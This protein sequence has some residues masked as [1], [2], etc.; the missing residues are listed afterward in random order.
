MT[1]RTTTAVIATL[2]VLAAL[3][4]LPGLDSGLW[5]DE[6]VTL[7]ESVRLPFRE[8][9]AVFPGNNNHPFYSLL[10]HLSVSTLGEHPWTLR[11]PAF[12]FGVASIP[13]LYRLGAA[14]TSRVESLLAALLLAVAYHAVW[15]SQNAR[16][17]TALL[18]FTL[19]TTLLFVRLSQRFD[20]KLAVAYGVL[21]GLGIYTHLTM[22]FLAGA[23][24]LVWSWQVW[25]AL[26][27]SER[28]RHIRT[29]GLALGAA[30]LVSGLLYLPMAG[31]V[32]Q[33]LNG[34][35]ESSAAVATPKWA[36][37]E[38]L[39]G[40]RI[41]L[42]T[43]GLLIALT[44]ASLGTMSHLR[45]MP[46]IV[47]LFVLP[48]V[49]TAVAML[50]MGAPIRPRFFFSLL[51]FGLLMLVRGAIESERFVRRHVGYRAPRTEICGVLVVAL[52]AVMS[53][54]SLRNNYRYPKQDSGSCS[55]ARTPT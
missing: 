53:A 54:Y 37:F 36:M 20:R 11:L 10:A 18:F 55:V 17:Y 49:M 38:V 48:G 28:S 4:R 34:P 1:K 50:A 30:A 27:R 24:A 2:T 52:I 25:Q 23:H 26:D 5:F 13:A 9:V 32:Y 44:L 40:L 21:S 29:A 35:P 6:I 41:G 46:F 16:G 42:G 43:V 47:C 12:I 19:V 7:V 45:R 39:R 51:G 14:V 3:L 22:A 31:Q 33:V 15:F 8:L